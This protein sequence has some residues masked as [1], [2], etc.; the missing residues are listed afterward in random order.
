[1][2]LG[3]SVEH[4]VE[5]IRHELRIIRRGRR[6]IYPISELQRWLDASATRALDLDGYG[7]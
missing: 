3:V 4:F 6:R 5:H 2:S 1:M 7:H